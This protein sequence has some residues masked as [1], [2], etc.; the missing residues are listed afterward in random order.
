MPFGGGFFPPLIGGIGGAAGTRINR[1]LGR[2]PGRLT[3][4]AARLWPWP[5]VI[6]LV[7]LLGQ[8]P[9]G[10]LFNDTLIWN[11][12]LRL[13]GALCNGPDDKMD[14]HVNKS[15]LATTAA[16]GLCVKHACGFAAAVVAGCRPLRYNSPHA[17]ALPADHQT[18][19]PARAW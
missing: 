15:A 16:I 4:L 14:A 7:W 1:P 9:V 2:K 6:L 3:H 11:Y 12:R 5:L 10:Y 19:R 17:V 8:F 13:R 18:H